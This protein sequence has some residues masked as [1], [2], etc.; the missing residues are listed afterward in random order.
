MV[1]VKLMHSFTSACL[2]FILVSFKLKLSD[3]T[4][5]VSLVA[6]ASSR[7]DVHNAQEVVDGVPT[8]SSCFW[9]APSVSSWWELDLGVEVAINKIRITHSVCCVC[10]VCSVT[11]CV[12]CVCV[13]VCVC[14][15]FIS[16]S[17]C[18]V[19][20]ITCAIVTHILTY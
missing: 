7:F 3:T 19:V 14:V 13:C 8:S 6:N 16:I 11:V 9:S 12:L 17:S 18:T 20:H 15:C 5:I 1:Y 4:F 2:V 10:S